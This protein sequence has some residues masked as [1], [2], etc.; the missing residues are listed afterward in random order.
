M[1]QFADNPGKRPVATVGFG[2]EL[3]LR[4]RLRHQISKAA[5][6]PLTRTDWPAYEYLRDLA[7]R[8]RRPTK[9]AGE[10]YWPVAF[11]AGCL[12]FMAGLV[13]FNRPH[14]LIFSPE[15]NHTVIRVLRQYNDL[16]WQIQ[17]VVDAVPQTPEVRHFDEKPTFEIGYTLTKLEVNDR[18]KFWSIK[19]IDPYFIALR[20]FTGWPI[21]PANC[22]NALGKPVICDGTPRW[23][24]K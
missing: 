16:D 21:I 6:P 5:Y 3:Y 7:R 23:E 22:T 24:E 8:L 15:N 10:S 12:L 4:S 17:R 20:D 19:H 11:A 18:G 14:P 2:E 13:W 9:Q 1:Q